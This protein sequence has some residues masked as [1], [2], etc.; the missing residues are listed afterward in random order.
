MKLKLIGFSLLLVLAG[1][2]IKCNQ[3]LASP[4][5]EI[6]VI[7]AQNSLDLEVSEGYG[8]TISFQKTGEKI[9]QAWLADPSQIAFSTNAN[10]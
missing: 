1:E 7:Q 5:K 8:L 4:V 9:T 6:S 2:V 10:N 3:T